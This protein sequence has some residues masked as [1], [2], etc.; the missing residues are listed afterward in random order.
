MENKPVITQID[1]EVSKVPTEYLEFNH[2]SIGLK[3]L[4]IHS[5]MSSEI[6][7]KDIES[8]YGVSNLLQ[9]N[10]K[11]VE[12]ILPSK[13]LHQSR[14]LSLKTKSN[15]NDI[16][17]KVKAFLPQLAASNKLLKQEQHLIV[18]ETLDNLNYSSV[19]LTTKSIVDII[20]DAIKTDLNFNGEILENSSTLGFGSEEIILNNE[21][22]QKPYVD[23][24]IILY[25]EDI[26]DE[27]SDISNENDPED[28]NDEDSDTSNENENCGVI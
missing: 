1:V 8:S 18:D 27:D 3:K 17:A 16:M 11:N 7:N 22:L 4:I 25:P 19:P 26:S 21:G 28:N 14:H 12:K 24:D 9:L 5:T 23:M 15:V 2:T 6:T 10:K 13:S 20:P